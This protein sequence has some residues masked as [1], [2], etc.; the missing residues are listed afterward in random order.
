MTVELF[1]PI[2][3]FVPQLLERLK[4]EYEAHAN[5]RNSANYCN[6]TGYTK[7]QKY[8]E[9][10]AE[11]ELVHAKMVQDFLTDF[12]VPFSIPVIDVQ[13]KFESLYDTIVTGYEIEVALYKAYTKMALEAMNA[14][15]ALFSLLQK[16]CDIQYKSVAE[17]RTLLDKSN[18]VDFGNKLDIFVFESTTFN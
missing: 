1:N 5:Y 17:Y 2:A 7:A 18:L 14:D 4:N 3:K 15:V 16:M 9:D 13:D 11:D 6:I 12:N 8:F 10:E